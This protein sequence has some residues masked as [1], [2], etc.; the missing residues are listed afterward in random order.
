M[1]IIIYTLQVSSFASKYLSN[2]LRYILSNDTVINKDLGGRWCRAVVAYF[3]TLPE[4]LFGQI[5]NIFKYQRNMV[6]WPKF[7]EGIIGSHAADSPLSAG[8]IWTCSWTVIKW[9]Y[10]NIF[11]NYIN[12]RWNTHIHGV[13]IEDYMNCVLW[14]KILDIQC[15]G[16]LVCSVRVFDFWWIMNWEECERSIRSQ[17]DAISWT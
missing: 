2:P 16:L 10:I 13:R 6:S 14:F 7:S 3:N 1:Y 17:I 9:C 12:Y 4:A 5:K 8:N 15:L 11:T